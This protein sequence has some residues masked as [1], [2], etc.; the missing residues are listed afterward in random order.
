MICKGC[1]RPIEFG[2][3][4][5][6]ADGR[7]R[8]TFC[9]ICRD[10]IGKGHRGSPVILVRRAKANGEEIRS[11]RNDTTGEVHTI[12]REKGR[13]WAQTER[14]FIKALRKEES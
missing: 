10:W 12:T 4:L 7:P 1:Q 13:S 14:A 3:R 5:S 9:P 8:G 2:T 6:W 11:Y